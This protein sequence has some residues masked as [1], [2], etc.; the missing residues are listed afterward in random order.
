MGFSLVAENRGYS[1]VSLQWLLTAVV[2][3]VAQYQL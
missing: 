2:S 3:L 1:L